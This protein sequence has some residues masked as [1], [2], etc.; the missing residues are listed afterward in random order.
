MHIYGEGDATGE[1]S[2]SLAEQAKRSEP[3]CVLQHAHLAPQRT[4]PL[5]QRHSTRMLKMIKAS[6]DYPSLNRPCIMANAWNVIFPS[7]AI[8]VDR[9][10]LR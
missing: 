6:S 9:M 3:R 10:A 5:Q 2:V 4:S 7:P 8:H 1:R